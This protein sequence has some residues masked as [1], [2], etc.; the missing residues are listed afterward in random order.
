MD[1]YS[2]E[3]ETSLL[4]ARGRDNDYEGLRPPEIIPEEGRNCAET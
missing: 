2:L 1:N 3:S 4:F